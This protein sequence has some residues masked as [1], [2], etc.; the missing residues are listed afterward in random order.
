[1]RPQQGLEYLCA[2]LIEAGIVRPP[3]HLDR[4]HQGL[5]A[6]G[7]ARFFG[8]PFDAG[9]G[10]PLREVDDVARR[11]R[12]LL[13]FATPPRVDRP[14]RHAQVAEPVGADVTARRPSAAASAGDGRR[15]SVAQ[16]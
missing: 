8:A 7:V 9:A 4:L 16:S 13:G 3:R 12:L 14:A 5:V 2:R 11:V 10:R 15:V 6:A 1:V